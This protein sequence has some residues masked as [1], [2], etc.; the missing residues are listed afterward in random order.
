MFWRKMK[1][2]MGIKCLGVPVLNRGSGKVSLGM[3][4]LHDDPKE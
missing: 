1:E 4:H 3:W 2:R